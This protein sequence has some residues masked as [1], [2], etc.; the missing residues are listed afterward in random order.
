MNISIVGMDNEGYKAIV[1][2]KKE[3]NY[4]GNKK[5]YTTYIVIGCIGG[6]IIIAIIICIVVKQIK[7]RREN[8]IEQR[9]KILVNQAEEKAKKDQIGSADFA[10]IEEDD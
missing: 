10:G 6:A 9:Q 5:S 8:D 4:V 2:A 3:Y 1:I 7:K